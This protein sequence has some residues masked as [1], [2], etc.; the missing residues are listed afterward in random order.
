MEVN[1]I[2]TDEGDGEPY[3]DTLAWE[4]TLID[5]LLNFASTPKGLLLLQQTGAINEAVAYM[6]TRY[7]KKLQVSKTEKFGYGTMVTQVAATAPGIVALQSTGFVK[8]L[9]NG[10]WTI[11]ECGPDD[12]P[13]LRPAPPPMQPN[14]RA[15]S[16]T[17]INGVWTILECGPDD[18]PLL[19]PAPPP[20]QP[21]D[22]AS[23]KVRFHYLIRL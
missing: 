10:L 5:N 16:K 7:A 20:M 15:S 4:Q 9:I 18:R 22:R 11:L 14:D 19:R 8:T 1:K 6:Y 3:E 2:T 13:L 12:R 21:N 23:S 17:L